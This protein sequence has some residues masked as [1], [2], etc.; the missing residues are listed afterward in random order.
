MKSKKGGISGVMVAIILVVIF[1]MVIAFVGQAYSL[2]NLKFWGPKFE[3]AKREV[4]EQTDS[5]INGAIQQIAR[6]QLEYLRA[7]DQVEKDAICATLRNMY[8]D[9]TPDEIDDYRL[10]S[11]FSSCKYG[12]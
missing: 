1:M 9:I 11:F 10:S 8:P 7:E 2:W 6:S 12:Y 4:W 5:R 3:D